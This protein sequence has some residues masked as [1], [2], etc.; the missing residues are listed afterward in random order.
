MS[1]RVP[2]LLLAPIVVL[3][4]LPADGDEAGVRSVPI[5]KALT[6]AREID[7]L[8]E[9]G[10][11]AAGQPPNPAVDD[12]TFLRRAYLQIAGRIPT[13]EETRRFRHSKNAGKRRA[14]IDSL[15][16]SKGHQ[17]HLFNWFADLLRVKTR[18]QNRVSG[19]PYIH[20]LKQ[21]IADNKPYDRMVSELLTAEGAAHA[22]G[23]GATGYYLRDRGM[24][25]DNMSNTVRV[26]LGTRLEC[27]QCHNHPFDRWTQKEFFQ[28]A[29]FTGGI[30]YRD[31]SYERTEAGAQLR[32]IGDA[33]ALVAGRETER[34]YNRLLQPLQQ[35][36]SGS[37][38]G[39]ARLPHDYKYE[40]ARPN[41]PV[42]AN[43]IFGDEVVVDVQVPRERRRN[44][45]RNRRVN[46]R[47]RNNF[48]GIGTRAQYAQ[49][50][51]SPKNPR[52]TKVIA[53]RLWKRTF[54]RGLIEPVDDLKD[55]TVA[56]NPELMSYLERLMVDL[57]YDLRQFERVVFNTRTWQREAT[58]ADVALADKYLFPGP[59]L[60]RMT[61]EQAWDSMLALVVEELDQKLLPPESPRATAIYEQYE[62]LLS[63]PEDELVAQAQ[64]QAL[65]RT[66][67]KKYREMQRRLREEQAKKRTAARRRMQKD[68]QQKRSRIGRLRRELARAKKLRDAPRQAEILAELGKLGVRRQPRQRRPNRRAGGQL[69]RASDLPS[70]ARPGHFLRQFGQSDRE[71]IEAA[72]DGANVPQVLTLLNGFVDQHML[73]RGGSVVQNAIAAARGADDK[74]R[75]AFLAILNRAPCSDELAMWQEDLARNER[76]TV[77]DLIWTLVNTHEFRFVQ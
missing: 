50:M 31:T 15:L 39:L 14:L 70:P 7:R 43:T 66:D 44:P 49:W 75:T 60:R 45:R 74:I 1:Q 64:R 54:G 26:F 19:E 29:A 42:K 40:D 77:H 57:G 5:T 20:W 8:V 52:F 46:R 24:P 53:N 56:S 36:I 10:L 18:L 41:Q 48:P 47:M 67:P 27:A 55:D 32:D 4:L 12:A 58:S 28:M 35:G 21:A 3:P 59:L 34:A 65:R 63:V 22:R 72:N 68:Q 13:L 16:D 61:A 76:E 71:Q 25:E 51:T 69:V 6:A 11:A 73:G 33:L 62:R 37:G 2:R 9:K 23:N 17:S 30:G 38:A